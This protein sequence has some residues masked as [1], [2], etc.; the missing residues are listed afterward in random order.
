[1]SGRLPQLEPKSPREDP[2]RRDHQKAVKNS[3]IVLPAFGLS[4]L[5][6]RVRTASEREAGY[7]NYRLPSEPAE[8]AFTLKG[9]LRLEMMNSKNEYLQKYR[10]LFGSNTKAKDLSAWRSRV[11]MQ[12]YGSGVAAAEAAKA[13]LLP[14]TVAP[15]EF[16]AKVTAQRGMIVLLQ[17]DDVFLDER[18]T[19]LFSDLLLG[20]LQRDSRLLAAVANLRVLPVWQEEVR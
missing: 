12:A 18:R 8:V 15:D 9:A 2:A 10:R 13:M 5:A 3:L 1:M 6:A 4:L 7:E 11:Y 20:F 17:I 14:T 19:Q 16:L